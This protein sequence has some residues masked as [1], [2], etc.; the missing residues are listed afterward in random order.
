MPSQLDMENR[1]GQGSN[2]SSPMMFLK[3]GV[4]HLAPFEKIH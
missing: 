3:S 2:W 1:D 4:G